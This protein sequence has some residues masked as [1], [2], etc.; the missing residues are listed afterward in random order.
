MKTN[1][2]IVKNPFLLENRTNPLGLLITFKKHILKI[3]SVQNTFG[4]CSLMASECKY[5]LEKLSGNTLIV[6]LETAQHFYQPEK[7]P[8]KLKKQIALHY[9]KLLTQ[10]QGR[11]ITKALELHVLLHQKKHSDLNKISDQ[12]I[13]E[14]TLY[15]INNLPLEEFTKSLQNVSFTFTNHVL[16]KASQQRGSEAQYVDFAYNNS[17]SIPIYTNLVSA[18]EH[19]VFL[20]TGKII[21]QKP[22]IYAQKYID[23]TNLSQVF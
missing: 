7:I 9:K 16:V 21:E 10:H 17:D 22:T 14:I 11:D 5:F 23:N 19:L 20:Q 18:A 12:K 2:D 1:F 13:K 4:L 3:L 6:E 8:L 15:W